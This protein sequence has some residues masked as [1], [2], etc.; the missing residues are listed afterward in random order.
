MKR[1]HYKGYR[2][3]SYLEPGADYRPFKLVKEIGRVPGYDIPLTPEQEARVR[4]IFD[5]N[6][7][8]IAGGRNIAAGGFGHGEERLFFALEIAIGKST[9]AAKIGSADLHPD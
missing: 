9:L 5:E 2:S 3:Y 6:L 1:K 4:R 8:I 7:V